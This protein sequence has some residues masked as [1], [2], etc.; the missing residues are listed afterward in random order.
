MK[1]LNN[2]GVVIAAL[3]ST[4]AFA[5][6]QTDAL[7]PQAEGAAQAEVSGTQSNAAE[8]TTTKTE[9]ETIPVASETAEPAATG[10]TPSRSRIIEEV[11]VTA[12]K[13]EEAIQNVPISIAAFSAESLDARG[14]FDTKALPNITSA[15]TISEFGGFSF[16][17]IRGVGSDAF[18]PSADPSVTTYVDGVFVPTSQGFSTDFGGIERVEVLKG[19]QGT[20]FGRN[21]TGG[22]ISIVTKKPGSEFSS[23]ANVTI[24]NY[25]EHRAKAYLNVPLTDTLGFAVDALYKTLDSQYTH[26]SREIVPQ[27]S[28][29]GRLRINWQAIDS[30]NIDVSY[31]KSVQQGTGSLV[32]KNVNPSPLFSVIGV[33]PGG[34]TDNR[35]ADTDFPA[36]LDGGSDVA[37]AVMTWELNPFD[38]KLSGADQE[39]N[40]DYSAYDF[41]GSSL[42][43]VAFD[44]RDQFTKAKTAELQLLSKP[45]GLLADD[46]TYVFGLYYLKGEGGFEQI[47]LKPGQPL[48]SAILTNPALLNLIPNEAYTVLDPLLGF[49]DQN[50]AADVF[51]RG[52]VG[53]KSI[54]GYTQITWHATDEL[55]LTAGGRYQDEKRYLTFA[56][57]RAYV[58]A[59]DTLTG[60]LLSFNLQNN[61]TT[62]FSSRLVASY[63]P[64][65][66]TMLYV[67]RS[68]GFK[69]GTYNVINIYTPPSFVKPELVTAY[70]GG[71]KADFLDH[72]LRVN[73]AVFENRIKNKQVG[74]VSLLSGGAVS[75]DNAEKTKIR[76]VE[77]DITVTPMPDLNPGLV[78]TANGAYLDAEYKKYTGGQGYG[79]AALNYADAIYANNNDYSGQKVERTPKWSGDIALSQTLDA[80]DN[81]EIEM[82]VDVYYN[83]G[84]F[85]TPENKDSMKEDAYSLLNGH[86]S[87]KYRPWNLRVTVFG[88]NLLDKDYYIS[89]FQTDFGILHTLAYERQYGLSLDWSF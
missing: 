27:K 3:A 74:F 17:Y 71:M 59:T 37:S 46:F 51:A 35:V 70:E 30:L 73:A 25:G 88:K 11:V 58:P 77:F 52:A 24:G 76:G 5:D 22:A 87:Y 36:F 2:T 60:P 85:Y 9:L 29:S 50:I 44:T 23:S 47:Y 21:S 10:R 64:V 81:G 18:V 82:A 89:K 19:P 1:L 39:T 75:L 32:S 7:M 78:L 56:D 69:S 16:I 43:L 31:F 14:V 83:D 33:V 28:K 48:F 53:T 15:M 62:N 61:T 12:Q 68:Q 6:P 40:S 8:S 84:F 72:A 42:P 54:S 63:K 26:T 67:A 65:D 38:L 86:A 34:T 66:D 57:T 79:R 13:R 80:G 4:A 45:G 20:L 49:L 55:D 41:D